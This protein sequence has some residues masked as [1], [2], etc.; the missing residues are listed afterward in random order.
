[1]QI[2]VTQSPKSNVFG[3]ALVL[4]YLKK[5]N[6]IFNLS[7]CKGIFYIHQGF[8]GGNT[9]T[10]FN[11]LETQSESLTC[12]ADY[13]KTNEFKLVD[14]YGKPTDHTIVYW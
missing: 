3:D 7:L 10:D 13:I 4:A 11:N 1:M 9:H 14:I 6:K 12:I 2:V 5:D 8:T